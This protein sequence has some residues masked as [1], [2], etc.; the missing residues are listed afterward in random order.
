MEV[1]NNA[2]RMFI[3][4]EWNYPTLGLGNY[5]KN[6]IRINPR[7]SNKVIMRFIESLEK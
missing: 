4:N 6:P 3:N 2:V 1:R 5:M 7:Y